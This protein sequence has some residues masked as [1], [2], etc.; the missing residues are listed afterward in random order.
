MLLLLF[1][2]SSSFDDA[3]WSKTSTFR[4]SSSFCPRSVPNSASLL[5]K[6]NFCLPNGYRIGAVNFFVG[7]YVGRFLFNRFVEL[8]VDYFDTNVDDGIKKNKTKRFF[9]TTKKKSNCKQ[10]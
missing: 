8:S 9:W 4:S 7:S 6:F 10:I 5:G 2:R 3:Y 1:D